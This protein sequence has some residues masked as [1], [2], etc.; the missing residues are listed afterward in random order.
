M[1]NFM[2]VWLKNNLIMD[3][4][5]LLVLLFLLIICFSTTIP[6]ITPFGA[7]FFYIIYY[8]DKYNLLFLYHAEFES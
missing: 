3:I 8:I 6:L 7:L 2:Q 4:I 5:I 1:Q